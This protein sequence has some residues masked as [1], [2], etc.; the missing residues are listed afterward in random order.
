LE[1]NRVLTSL[2]NEYKMQIKLGYKE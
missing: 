1:T 2:Q